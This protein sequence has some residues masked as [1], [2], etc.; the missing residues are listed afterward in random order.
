DGDG[1]LY[2]NAKDS[3]GNAFSAT[4]KVAY[5]TGVIDITFTQAPPEGT[6]IAVQVEINI[7][8]NPSL[9]PVI[10]QAMRKYEVRPSQYVIASEH[11]V[12]SASD[13]S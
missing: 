7:E 6:E 10:N 2:F 12:M 1:N 5:D 4:A 8:R 11:T 3:K 9:I 13:L